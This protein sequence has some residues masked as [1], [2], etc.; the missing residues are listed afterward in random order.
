MID[1]INTNKVGISTPTT[2]TK[3]G[4]NA[5]NY[6]DSNQDHYEKYEKY[7]NDEKRFLKITKEML[8]KKGIKNRSFKEIFK[9][10]RLQWGNYSKT[11]SFDDIFL[12]N[13]TYKEKSKNVMRSNLKSIGFLDP[14][15]RFTSQSFDEYVRLHDARTHSKREVACAKQDVT[16]NPDV[17]IDPILE[18][19]STMELI[20]ENPT[21]VLFHFPKHLQDS[22]KT[23]D[24]NNTDTLQIIKL[25]HV[26]G[27]PRTPIPLTYFYN[28]VC[29]NTTEL[30]YDQKDVLCDEEGCGRKMKRVPSKDVFIAGYA[31]Q[32]IADD[33]NNIPIL[34]M[35]PIPVGEF[36][37]SVFL[38]RNSTGYY[39][40]MLTIEDIVIKSSD[41]EINGKDHAIWQ[42]IQYIDDIHEQRLGKHIH[43]MDWYKASILLSYLANMQRYTSMNVFAF[44][45][46]GTGKT[47]VLRFYLSTLTR[48]FKL[49]DA[50]TLSSAGLYGSSSMIKVGDSVVTIPEAGFLSR[51]DMV[52]LD[53]A[54]LKGVRILPEL[55]SLL[56]SS[57]INKEVAGNRTSMPKNACVIGTSN[58]IPGVLIAQSRWMDS[59]LRDWKYKQSDD[60]FDQMVTDDIKRLAHAHMIEEWISRDLDWHTG[61]PFPDLDRWMILFFIKKNDAR[62]KTHHLNPDDLKIDDLQMSKMFYDQS[63]HDY[64][65]FCSTIKVNYEDI[66]EKILDFIEETRK[67]DKIH[68]DRVG[69]DIAL[70]LTLSAQINGRSEINENDFDFVRALWGKTCRWIDVSELSHDQDSSYS[71]SK[72]TT[73][74]IK[75]HI[76]TT[77]DS[78]KSSPKHYM[79]DR[80]FSLVCDGLEKLGADR[81]LVEFVVVKYRENPNQ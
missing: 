77:M 27:N 70:V 35:V 16:I 53:E 41:I 40:F 26:G 43:G 23:L 42:L 9:L 45:K 34:S 33:F 14:D 13:D 31:S 63:V 5:L 38:R 49:Q 75:K 15:W 67:H 58:P 47:S 78:Y 4:G 30:T 68:S 59:W 2:K 55:R 62:L 22:A 37:A 21:D 19:H 66:S 57:T 71:S 72:W 73:E 6:T 25:H 74:S 1:P 60:G 76:H 79:T 46:G 12:K 28:C 52:G 29:G 24:Y 65:A 3:C 54:Y 18:Y 50:L 11:P 64:F 56:R 48:Q 39:L 32:V 51:Y 10:L 81:E 80:G 17:Y 7:F 8:V 61:Q 36:N 20:R 44:G 69:A